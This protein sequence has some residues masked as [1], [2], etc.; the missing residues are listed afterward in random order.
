MRGRK[1]DRQRREGGAAKVTRVEKVS[2]PT[3]YGVIAKIWA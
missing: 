3:F 1:S 2:V